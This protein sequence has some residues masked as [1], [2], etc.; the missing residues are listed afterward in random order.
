MGAEQS[1]LGSPSASEV[2]D[3]LVSESSGEYFIVQGPTMNPARARALRRLSLVLICVSWVIGLY[4]ANYYPTHS[5]EVDCVA[6]NARLSLDS[7]DQDRHDVYGIY[8]GFD[9]IGSKA[10]TSKYLMVL[11]EPRNACD[12]ENMNISM[13]A[14]AGGLGDASGDLPRA[15][16][17]TRGGCTFQQ[18]MNNLV[19]H[20]VEFM[21]EYD[22]LHES[23]C[24]SMEYGNATAF[25][26]ISITSRA[27]YRVES[28][29]V[30]EL[31]TS[32][33]RTH[34]LLFGL[35]DWSELCLILY[36]TAA[37][38]VASAQG[39]DADDLPIFSAFAS[40]DDDSNNAVHILSMNHAKMFA[41]MA[42]G[43]LL[44]MYFLSSSLLSAI[45]SLGFAVYG[46]D[47]MQE[48]LNY[49]LKTRYRVTYAE[50]W[51]AALPTT[52]AVAWLADRHAGLW[53][54][55]Q[56]TL[57]FFIIIGTLRAIVAPSLKIAATL[58]SGACLYD[59]FWV[60]IQPRLTG[61]TSVMIDAVGGGGLAMPLFVAFPQMCTIGH[62]REYSLLGLGDIVIPGLFIVYAADRN[63]MYR[64][65]TLAAYA[66]GLVAC[67]VALAF[68]IGGQGGQPALLYISPVLLL[69]YIC[70][71]KMTCM[72][73]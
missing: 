50:I 45:F 36:A 68:D 31:N 35:F 34:E 25:H 39:S 29:T 27:G 57:A 63:T 21:V 38:F 11:V 22:P 59:V 61:S 1:L 70:I 54:L 3:S 19:S 7:T 14:P 43:M 28:C 72:N 2:E 66:F 58:L 37:L 30:A 26:G 46:W 62:A 65:P 69:T 64:P 41:F 10:S 18:K 13:C 9:D 60:Y 42:S 8:S 47:A 48:T 71:H 52:I 17:V 40:E 51:S 53:W 67:F 12:G 33:E 73:V 16:I 6:S 15:G 49:Y 4:V 5:K 32:P 23:T 44:L 55:W 24:L 56:N 20:G